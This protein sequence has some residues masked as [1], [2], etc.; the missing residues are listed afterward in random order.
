MPEADRQRLR[1]EARGA[2]LD[3]AVGGPRVVVK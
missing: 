3:G 2:I 1:Q